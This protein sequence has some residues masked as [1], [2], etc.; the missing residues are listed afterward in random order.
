MG[1][2]ILVLMVI[3]FWSKQKRYASH[4]KMRYEQE[5]RR[6]ETVAVSK[7]KSMSLTASMLEGTLAL[8]DFEMGADTFTGVD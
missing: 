1:V 8:K 5:M 2:E 3:H 7:E 4:K 6:R